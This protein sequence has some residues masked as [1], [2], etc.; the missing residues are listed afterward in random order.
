MSHIAKLDVGFN[1]SDYQPYFYF[2][3]VGGALASS[4]RLIIGVAV[5]GSSCSEKLIITNM[6]SPRT[7]QQDTLFTITQ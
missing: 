6:E 3:I 4:H 2:I 1:K 7:Q 5:V